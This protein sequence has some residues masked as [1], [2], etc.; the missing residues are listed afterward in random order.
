MK[1]L[2]IEKELDQVSGNAAL[3]T[4]ETHRVYELYKLGKI[5]EIYFQEQ[6]HCAVIVFEVSDLGEARDLINT[7]PLV[8]GHAID[9]DIMELVPYTG[10]D[11]IINT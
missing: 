11:R 8:T 6:N 10:L 5:R 4:E 7:L 3:L 9:F 2:A 1:V